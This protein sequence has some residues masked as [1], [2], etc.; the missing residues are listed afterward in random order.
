MINPLQVALHVPDKLTN[1]LPTDL[2][3][4]VNPHFGVFRFSIYP[5]VS[6]ALNA[7]ASAETMF[8]FLPS[9]ALRHSDL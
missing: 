8:A 2:L 3:K 6:A 4:S 5:S 7:T 9:V 1:I